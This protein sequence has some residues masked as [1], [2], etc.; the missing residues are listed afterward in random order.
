MDDKVKLTARLPAELSAWI[1]KRAAQN[2]RSQNRE[3]IAILK[4]AKATEARA[5]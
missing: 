5:A 1:A 3:I 2:E 4:A